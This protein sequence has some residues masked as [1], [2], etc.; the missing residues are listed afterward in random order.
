MQRFTH[1]SGEDMKVLITLDYEIFFGE[2][3][4]FKLSDSL[5][6]PTTQFVATL[7]TF[8]AK[9][10]FFVDAGFLW[11]M[12]K[13]STVYPTL[14]RDLAAIK[15][16]IQSLEKLGHEIQLHVHPHWEDSFFDGSKWHIVTKRYRL[17]QFTKT[18][19]EEIFTKYH[20]TLQELLSKQITAYRAGGWCIQ[21]FSQIIEVMKKCEIRFDSTVYAGGYELS[22]THYYDFRRSPSKDL[23]KFSEDPLKEDVNG[24]FT[25]VPIASHQISPTFF[26]RLLYEKTFKKINDTNRSGQPIKPSGKKI[27]KKLLT[28]SHDAV[29]LDGEKSK[30]VL[31]ALKNSTQSNQKHFVIIGHPKMFSETTYSQTRHIL[32]YLK[33]SGATIAGFSDLTIPMTIHA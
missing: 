31:K 7:D 5:L 1:L 9:A 3:N 4:G 13:E 20:R 6:S 26:W 15:D 29:S 10:V 12:E 27:L 14:K 32:A 17:D 33:S 28:R 24:L 8:D 21:P 2:S 23:W 30:L 25:E 16:Q 11:A 22:N 19:A 18:E